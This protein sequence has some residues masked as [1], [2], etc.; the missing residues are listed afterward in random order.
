M[1]DTELTGYN[2]DRGWVFEGMDYLRRAVFTNGSFA[3]QCPLQEIL[4]L[5][6]K[7]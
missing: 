5:L 7:R 6:R 2:A 1:Y 3:L 4:P